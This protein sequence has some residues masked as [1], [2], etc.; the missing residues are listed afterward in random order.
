VTSNNILGVVLPIKMN[1]YWLQKQ[2]KYRC[3]IKFYFIYF[4][5]LFFDPKSIFDLFFFDHFE[6]YGILYRLHK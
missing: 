3:V 4:L 5:T 6:S 2:I 1:F